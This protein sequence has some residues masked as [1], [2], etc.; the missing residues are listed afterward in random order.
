MRENDEG[1]PRGQ[2]YERRLT[3]LVEIEGEDGVTMMELFK[4]VRDECGVVIRCRYK[5]PREYELTM[6][7]KGNKE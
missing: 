5:T 6:K 2:T 1:A 7:D 3:E 4:K